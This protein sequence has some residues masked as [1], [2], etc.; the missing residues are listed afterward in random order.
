ML[1]GAY[2][3]SS[4][5]DPETLRGVA[6]TTYAGAPLAADGSIDCTALRSAL[7]ANGA[8]SYN[9]LLEDR[10]GRSYLSTVRCLEAL[11]N[12][13]IP[14]SGG[15][16]EFRAWLTL[17]PPTEAG[18]GVC[19]VPADS[20]LTPFNETAL[21]NASLGYRGCQDYR[22]WA[23]VAGRLAQQFPALRY[24]NVDDLTHNPKIFTPSLVAEMAALLRP[25]ARLIPVVY[26]GAAAGAAALPIDGILFYFR[27]EKEG[28]CPIS[29]GAAVVADCAT[30]WPSSGCLAGAGGCAEKTVP[31]LAGEVADVRALLP[32]HLPLHVGI[33]VTGRS[34]SGAHN[35]STPRAAYGRLALEAALRLPAVS[36]ATAYRMQ[37]DANP[38]RA[39][40]A[41][42]FSA[43]DVR[44]PART[45]FSYG[46]GSEGMFCCAS[47]AAFPG[48]CSGGDEGECCLSPG[49][50]QGCQGHALCQVCPSSR[51]HVYGDSGGTALRLLARPTSLSDRVIRSH[52]H[53][54]RTRP[55]ISVGPEAGWFCCAQPAASGTCPGGGECCTVPGEDEGC[56]GRPLCS[57]P[58]HARTEFTRQKVH[59]AAK[60]TGAVTELS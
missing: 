23:D 4:A 22:A 12:F 36:G 11:R 31:N 49:S 25:R 44:C 14:A 41:A 40:V 39:S 56:Q 50:A 9:F 3:V 29:C 60:A 21:F 58:S 2:G 51:P 43:L 54:L 45:P 52:P 5:S 46:G 1:L 7:V 34:P 24:L 32:S 18:G 27:N 17:I 15:R 6:L 20:P 48:H 10:D 37:V 59:N 57:E 53:P 19:S 47:T 28:G 16:V 26:Y 35:C 38:Q 30:Q 55:Y 8:N 13:T 42:A 33:Y